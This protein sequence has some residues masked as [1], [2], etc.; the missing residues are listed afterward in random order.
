MRRIYLWLQT[1]ADAA[2]VNHA[3]E[4]RPQLHTTLRARE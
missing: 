3:K 4:E 1:I 2:N